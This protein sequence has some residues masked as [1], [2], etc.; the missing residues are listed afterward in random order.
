MFEFGIVKNKPNVICVFTHRKDQDKEQEPFKSYT[1]F[2]DSKRSTEGGN[3][4]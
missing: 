4:A 3:S 1:L 2:P